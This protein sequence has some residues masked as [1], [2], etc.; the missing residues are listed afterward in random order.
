MPRSALLDRVQDL[1]GSLAGVPA[2]FPADGV[3]VVVAPESRLCPPGWVGIVVVGGSGIATAPDAATARFLRGSLAGGPPRAA[4]EPE[5]WSGRPGVVDMLGPASLAYLDEREFR[6][7]TR[8]ADVAR[9][10]PGHPDL[11]RT[12]WC[13]PTRRPSPRCLVA[14]V[15]ADD[16]AESGIDDITSPVFVVRDGGQVAAAAG[17]RQWPGSVAHLCV[18]TSTRLR[19]RGL[20]REVASAAVADAL[21]NHLLPQWRARPEPSRRLARRLGFQECGAQLSLRIAAHQGDRDAGVTSGG[22]R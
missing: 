5:R 14:D 6:P 17:Y 16:V 3:R 15:A 11:D 10:P 8:G 2:G 13:R 9:L 20:A 4:V 22:A 1:W 21:Q 19:G 18:L 7:A 12:G